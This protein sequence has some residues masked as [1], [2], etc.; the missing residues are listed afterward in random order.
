M[1]AANRI[2]G[3]QNRALLP[4]GNARGVFARQ[5]DPA[6]E[7]AKVVIMLGPKRLSP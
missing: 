7:G 2:Q 5:H 3:G 6:I 1:K 4:G